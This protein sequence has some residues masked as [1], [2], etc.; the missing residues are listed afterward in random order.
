MKLLLVIAAAAG[1]PGDQ[2]AFIA[3]YVARHRD[4][5]CGTHWVDNPTHAQCIAMLQR[6]ARRLYNEARR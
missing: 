1:A 5:V 3:A 6:E 2:E 4:E